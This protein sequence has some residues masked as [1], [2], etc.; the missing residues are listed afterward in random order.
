MAKDWIPMREDLHEDPAVLAMADSLETRPEH[1]VGYCHKFWSWLSRNA[2]ADCLQN[3]RLMSVESVLNLPGFLRLLCEV[4]WLEE[5]QNDAGQPCLRVPN[6]DRW[7]SQSGKR[8][9]LESQRKR[10]QRSEN[11]RNASAKRPQNVPP[12]AGLQDRT[13]QDSNKGDKSPLDPLPPGEDLQAIES[14]EPP[15]LRRAVTDWLAYKTERKEKYK[16]QGLKAF[17]SR[18]ATLKLEHGHAPV[19]AAI[20]RA[21]SNGWKGFDQDFQ[22]RGSLSPG[23]SQ[24]PKT[25]TPW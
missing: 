20:E 11:V 15:E 8:R 1:I 6:F 3:V 17:F 2:S 22:S 14:I 9:A 13:G 18:V 16:P 4:G 21:M 19:C 25:Y 23:T 5:Y 24:P 10:S 7:L 12:K